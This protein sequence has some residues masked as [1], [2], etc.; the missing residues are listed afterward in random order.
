MLH[1]NAVR[2]GDIR[3]VRLA[4]EQLDV[5]TGVRSPA[6]RTLEING[7]QWRSQKDFY[8]ALTDL[9]GGVERNCRSSGVFLDTMIY[10]PG[11]NL[12][13]PPYEVLITN[14]PAAL[15][16]FLSEF[17]CDVA[18][19]RQDRRADPELGDDVAVVITVA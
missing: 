2:G 6:M 8:D 7:S 1:S 19:A 4:D 9:L 16:P 11:L 10:Y 15:R 5:R 12:E 13:Q 18:E 14:S 3:T 17:A